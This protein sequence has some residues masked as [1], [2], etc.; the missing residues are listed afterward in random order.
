M[1]SDAGKIFVGG[2]PRGCSQET[3]TGWASQFG[4]VSKVEVKLGPDGAPRGFGF[5]TFQDPAAAQLVVSNKDNN[6]LDGK[7]I[8]CK[9]A[10]PPGSAPPPSKGGGKGGADLSNPRDTSNPKIF[11][12]ALPKTAT[13]DAVQEFFSSYGPVKEVILKMADDGQC[14]GFAFVTFEA[15]ATAQSVLENYDNNMFEGKWIDCKAL[16]NTPKGGKGEKGDKGKGG[17]KGKGKNKGGFG[18][19]GCGGFGGG[20]SGGCDG[21]YGGGYGGGACNG[22]VGGCSGGY[23]GGCGGCF[24]GGCGGGCGGCSGGYGGGFGAGGAQPPAYGGAGFGGGCC[25][26]GAPPQAMEGNYTSMPSPFGAPP[27][28]YGG[29]PGAPFGAAAPF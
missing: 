6:V 3:L 25:A 19:A 4:I 11:V 8:D 18:N 17:G 24:P 28:N 12:G 22:C 7:W 26:Y 16:Q 1:A 29:V 15:A 13:Q 27:P 21:G 14:K 10:Q 2:L 5:V 9:L 20:F 23:G